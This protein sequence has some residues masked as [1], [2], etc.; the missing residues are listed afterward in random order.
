MKAQ[1][2]IEYAERE[3][4]ISGHAVLPPTDVE[5]VLSAFAGSDLDI[6]NG[7]R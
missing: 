6:K 3:I 4:A 2:L 7:A 1:T 5:E